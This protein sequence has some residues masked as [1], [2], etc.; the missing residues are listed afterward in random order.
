V[1]VALLGAAVPAVALTIPSVAPKPVIDPKIATALAT[2]PTTDVIVG[3]TSAPTDADIASLATEGFV[4]PFERYSI[5]PAVAAT[6][7]AASMKAVLGNTRVARVEFDQVLNYNLDRATAVAKA[8]PVWTADYLT[9]AGAKSGGFTGR[10]VTVAVVDSG[11]DGRHPDLKPAIKANFVMAGRTNANEAGNILDPEDLGEGTTVNE[12]LEADATAVAVP[13]SDNGGH[14]THVAGIVAS[15]GTQSDGKY[16]GVAPSASLVGLSV[17]EALNVSRGLAAFDWIHK[18][19]KSYGIKVVTNSWGG[20]GGEAD[21]T[22]LTNQAIRKLIN[23]DGLVVLFSAGNDGGDGT[24]IETSPTCNIAEVICVANYYDRTGYLDAS[25]SRGLKTNP[26]TWP[27]LAAPGTQIISTAMLGGP[28]TYYGTAQDGA[29][30]YLDGNGEPIVVSAPVKARTYSV[31]GNDVI[32]GDYA[33][34]TGTSMATPVVAGVVALLLQANPSLTPA[35]VQAIL[36]RT[37]NMVPGHSFATDGFELGA[38]V[39][40]AAEAVAVALKM[41]D[42]DSLDDALAHASLDL[43]TIPA[44]INFGTG[45]VTD[46]SIPL[47]PTN[48]SPVTAT[49]HVYQQGALDAFGLTG[50]ERMVTGTNVSLA[51]RTIHSSTPSIALNATNF[52]VTFFVMQGNTIKGQYDGVIAA[53]DPDWQA[54]ADITVPTNWKGTDYKLVGELSYGASV[55]RLFSIPVVVSQAPKAVNQAS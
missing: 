52:T 23:T 1:L 6:A 18:K 42:G 14:G 54:T 33:S 17:G 34:L 43:T 7:T 8:K 55:Y 11:I 45:P 29:V 9:A 20:A 36:K 49:G 16:K 39:V 37:A 15:R 25:S 32:V 53:D 41:K 28:V 10:G 3:F 12:T 44:R 48:A 13:T 19:G 22:T 26:N 5:V 50:T 46:Q 51:A 30:G 24:T 27:D 4:G 47:M 21:P 38:G 2:S 31:A 40:D 35:Q